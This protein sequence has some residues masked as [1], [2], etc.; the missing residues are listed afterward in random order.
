M[1]TTTT[2]FDSKLKHI[3]TTTT[4]TLSES[5][6][7]S[8]GVND[9][10]H[11]SAA[12]H[13]NLPLPATVGGVIVGMA[14]LLILTVLVTRLVVLSKRNRKLIDLASHGGM[15]RRYEYP[16]TGSSKGVMLI[17]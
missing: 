8:S 15:R 14:V 10:V 9:V 1:T 4:M 17:P 11:N 5:T 16:L 12:N 3:H 6:H 13:L 2:I 7:T